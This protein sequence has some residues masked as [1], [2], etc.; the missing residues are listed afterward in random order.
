MEEERD[1]KAQL[2]LAVYEVQEW[3]EVVYYRFRRILWTDKVK[4][5]NTS[6]R[7][8]FEFAQLAPVDSTDLRPNPGTPS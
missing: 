5:C 1:I 3:D 6:T 7:V 4:P 8:E 2:L